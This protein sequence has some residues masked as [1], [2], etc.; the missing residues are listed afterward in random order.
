MDLDSWVCIYVF[1]EE[2]ALEPFLRHGRI[3]IRMFSIRN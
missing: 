2:M 3:T 1:E